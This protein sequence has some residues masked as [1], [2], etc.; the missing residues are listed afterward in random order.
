MNV[1]QRYNFSILAKLEKARLKQWGL[2]EPIHCTQCNRE[3]YSEDSMKSHML[4]RHG[5]FISSMDKARDMLLITFKR[6][7]E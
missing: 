4:F 3:F 2:S 5:R 1:T 6:L 7:S